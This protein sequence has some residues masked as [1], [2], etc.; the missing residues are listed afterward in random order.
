MNK[1]LISSASV[2]LGSAL[3]THA[4]DVFSNLGAGDS[5]DVVGRILQGET[6]GTI[7]NVDQASTFTV[8]AISYS[9]TS[10]ELGLGISATGPLDVILAADAGGSPGATLETISLNLNAGADTLAFA[11]ASGSTMLD[12]NTTYWV[13]ADAKGSFDGAWRFNTTGDTGL[14]AGRSAPVNSTAYGPWNLRPDDER[15]ALRVQ[16]NVVPEPA[17]VVLLLL[18]FGLAALG[19][20][21]RAI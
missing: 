9:L 8:G 6:V 10:L 7:G 12:A 11:A 18:G 5:F 2:I 3:L 1:Y 15:Y 20:R 21:K 4:D 19:H 17:S 13:I 16:G 14:T